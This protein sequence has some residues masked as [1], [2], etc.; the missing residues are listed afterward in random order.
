MADHP[1]TATEVLAAV[2][3]ATPGTRAVLARVRCK[4]TLM[5]LRTIVRM[6]AVLRRHDTRRNQRAQMAAGRL[7]CPPDAGVAMGR[8][9]SSC[10]TDR[11]LGIS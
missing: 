8:S 6:I 9:R 1:I 11:R 7:L 2:V 10:D 5:R 3:H 4:R